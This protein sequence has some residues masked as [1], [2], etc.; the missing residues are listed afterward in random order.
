MLHDYITY[1]LIDMLKHIAHFTFSALLL[2]AAVACKQSP[3]DNDSHSV[4]TA[5]P[6]SIA[7]EQVADSTIYG[8]S[9]EF[10]MSTFTLISDQGDTLNV[11]RTRED[12]TD[13]EVYGDMVEGERYAL[14]TRDNGE[15]I[16]V[17]INLTQLDKHCKDYTIVNGKVIV[18]GDTLHI[19][20][21]SDQTFKTK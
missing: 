21:L 9:D 17:L 13:G 20:E 8:T 2:T 7:A 15:S 18:K 12:G 11:A 4:D 3:K 10:G 14:T 6:D 1:T 5:P 16:G 19:E